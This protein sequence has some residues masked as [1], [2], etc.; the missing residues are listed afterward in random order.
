MC[1]LFKLCIYRNYLFSV[2]PW[3]PVE[4]Q[5]NNRVSTLQQSEVKLASAAAEPSLNYAGGCRSVTCHSASLLLSQIVQGRGSEGGR[6]V[7]GCVLKQMKM[8]LSSSEFCF[9][10]WSVSL[11]GGLGFH[12]QALG[13]RISI[14]IREEYL[15]DRYSSL[16]TPCLLLKLSVCYLSFSLPAL[17]V[18]LLIRFVLL[19]SP[20]PGLF[21]QR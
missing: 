6:K 14:R 10:Q 7:L 3:S 8:T 12:W 2:T 20:L 1:Q 18:P 13:D 5:T 9:E 19:S 17:T 21:L 15:L 4:S 16:S 11:R